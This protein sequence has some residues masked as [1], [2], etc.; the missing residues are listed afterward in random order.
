MDR[1][2]RMGHLLRCRVRCVNRISRPRR[3]GR[4]GAWCAPARSAAR[5][6][7]RDQ[8][9]RDATR[10]ASGCS[11]ARSAARAHQPHA[12]WRSGPVARRWTRGARASRHRPGSTPDRTGSAPAPGARPHVRDAAG[13]EQR[14]DN[15]EH[16]DD[17]APHDDFHHD[18]PEQHGPD[19][20]AGPRRRPR[21]CS[22]RQ[23]QR[24]PSRVP[25]GPAGLWQ[26]VRRAVPRRHGPGPQPGH[27]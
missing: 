1:S 24:R 15:A 8:P 13:G 7:R 20:P 19:H 5:R 12:R 9:G 14:R 2:T 4:V 26:L 16:H 6:H 21:A 27:G 23:Q 11:R 3:A 22:R 18:G 10:G 25:P 17:D